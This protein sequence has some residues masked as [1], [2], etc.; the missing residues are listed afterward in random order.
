MTYL[1]G[2]SI[3]LRIALLCSIIALSIFFTV[4]SEVTA[5]S[6]LD[7]LVLCA[8][9]VIPSLF[10]FMVL[11]AMA[12]RAASHFTGKNSARTAVIL[13]VFLGCLCGFPVGAATVASMYRNGALSKS[14]AE[15]LCALCNNT[16]PAFIIGVIGR[17][18]WGGS[19][20]GVMFYICQIVSA[21]LVFTV[22]RIFF[23]KSKLTTDDLIKNDVKPSEKASGTDTF[24]SGFC[25]SVAESA[26]SVVQ[27]CG[28][29]VFFKVICDTVRYLVP[30]D[31]VYAI[32]SS[33]LEFTSGTY[34]AASLEGTLGIALCGF[35]IGFSGLSV[36]AQSAGI[37]SR[38]GLSVSPLFRLKIFTGLV[39]AALSQTVYTLRD[40][41]EAVFSENTYSSYTLSP[42]ISLGI[43]VIF[44]V[45]L[46]FSGI[47]YKLHRG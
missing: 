34:A 36:M 24:C 31:T 1:Y 18:F 23:G 20:I 12:S 26:V 3:F 10:P 37:L 28:Y 25:N 16:G 14:K 6:A 27:I 4:Y 35:S 39:C 38:A 21:V 41:P 29:I 17:S 30:S 7:S 19:E 32:L 8:T 47:R 11:S 43:I 44:A 40:F 5:D 13:P 9:S 15:Y 46:T 45:F 2:K 42:V 33:I 22:W